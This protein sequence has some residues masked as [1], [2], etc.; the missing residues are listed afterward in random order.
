[1]VSSYHGET[2]VA[3]ID[4]SG[5]AEIAGDLR[6]AQRVLNEFYNAIFEFCENHTRTSP[7]ISIIVAS[8]CA[9]L[10]TRNRTADD[11]LNGLSLILD[12]IKNV[13]RRFITSSHSQPFMT[14]CSIAYGRFDYED[15]VEFADLR[16]NYLFGRPYLDVVLDQKKGKPKIRA[17]ECR[18]LRGKMPQIGRHRSE[19]LFSFVL[20]RGNRHY[21]YWMLNSREHQS[22]FNR[23]YQIAYKSRKR[24]NYSKV[25]KVLQKYIDQGAQPFT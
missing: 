16:K 9:I 4:I 14:T 2:Y 17:G 23:D 5:F 18:L 6:S 3:Y 19:P 22:S 13:N 15:R 10:F 1:M 12:F 7:R 8:D 25:I 11:R 21:F 24:D 20:K